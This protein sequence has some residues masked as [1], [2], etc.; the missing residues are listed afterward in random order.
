MTKPTPAPPIDD[1]RIARDVARHLDRRRIRRRLLLWTFLL[2]VVGAAAAYLR[3]GAG[4]GLGGGGH[5][6]GDEPRA[7]QRVASGLRCGLRLSASGIAVDGKRMAGDAAVARC[8]EVGGAAVLV[9]GDARHGDRDDLIAALKAAGVK[10][11]IVS[12]AHETS[13]GSGAR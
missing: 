8:A 13:A 12:D 10:D 5:G 7:V 6:D 4:F 2:A 11:I 3:C 1:R 9:T